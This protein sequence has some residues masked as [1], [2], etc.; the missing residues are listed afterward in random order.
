M[1]SLLTRAKELSRRFRGIKTTKYLFPEEY[2][3]LKPNLVL[4]DDALQEIDVRSVELLNEH[5]FPCY[6]PNYDYNRI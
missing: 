1:I 6:D 4:N 3:N 2:A 5:Y